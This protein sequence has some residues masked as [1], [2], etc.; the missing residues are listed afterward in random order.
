MRALCEC[1]PWRGGL[2]SRSREDLTPVRFR[3]APRIPSWGTAAARSA[4][5]WK[6]VISDISESGCPA[7]SGDQKIR[8]L[9]SGRQPD[10]SGCTVMGCH[11]RVGFGSTLGRDQEGF[12]GRMARRAVGRAWTIATLAAR[13]HQNRGCLCGTARKSAP[14][15]GR[16][17]KGIA[18][19]LDGHP[20][21]SSKRP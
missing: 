20:R 2:P 18:I 14:N 8:P 16:M 15:K 10:R 3:I 6:C 1:A 13:A 9:L 7:R 19:V 5:G 4:L 17:L 12:S 11:R 21:R